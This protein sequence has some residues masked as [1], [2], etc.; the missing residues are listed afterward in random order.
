MGRKT[1]DRRSVTPEKAIEI[2]KI[3]GTIVTREEAVIILDFM[4]RL[5]NL[6]VEQYLK[7]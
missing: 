6:S 5:A 4:Y 1:Q 7:I 3:S 2:L